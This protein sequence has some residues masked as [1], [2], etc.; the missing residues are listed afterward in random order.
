MEMGTLRSIFFVRPGCTQLQSVIHMIFVSM[1]F[2]PFHIVW[3]CYNFG[4]DNN[5]SDQLIVERLKNAKM[6]K[7]EELLVS[8]CNPMCVG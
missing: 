1:M 2:E 3:R 4:A 5:A 6:I 8:L 7:L